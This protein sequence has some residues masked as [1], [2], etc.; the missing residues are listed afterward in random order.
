M[1]L[2]G[3]QNKLVWIK[4]EAVILRRPLFVHERLKLTAY[5]FQGYTRV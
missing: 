2:N 4:K 3:V 1:I 5:I